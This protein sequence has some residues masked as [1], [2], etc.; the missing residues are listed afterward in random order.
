MKH[1]RIFLLILIPFCYA[2]ANA[3][4]EAGEAAPP[5]VYDLRLVVYTWPVTGILHSNADLQS[6]PP[7]FFR[8][9]HGIQRVELQ[10]SGFSPPLRYQGMEPP[11]LFSVETQP[12]AEGPPQQRAVPRVRPKIDP[13]WTEA[14]VIVYP[15]RRDRD[16]TWATLA[17]PTSRLEI[18]DGTSRFLNLTHQMLAIELAGVIHTISPGGDIQLPAPPEDAGERVRLN[19]HARDDIRNEVRMIH[20][21]AVRREN[22]TGNLY[23]IHSQSNGRPRVLH[24][25]Q[26]RD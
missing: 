18:P 21:T 19:I 13:S 8:D 11:M 26:P 22:A 4:E 5:P 15:E 24:L 6:L 23:L 9:I 14:T 7:V 17:V 3:E 25:A 10:R 16:G 1:L 2:V 20:T 12:Q